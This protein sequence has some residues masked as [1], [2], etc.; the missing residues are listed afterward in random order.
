MKT[1]II[2]LFLLNA[3]SIYG[4]S[5]IYNFYKR[6]FFNKKYELS[7][8]SYITEKIKYEQILDDNSA[9]INGYYYDSDRIK[10]IDTFVNDELIKTEYFSKSGESIFVRNFKYDQEGR[11]EYIETIAKLKNEESNYTNK[12]FFNYLDNQINFNF[13]INYTLLQNNQL[14][15]FEEVGTG[16]LDKNY[17]PEKSQSQFLK[18]SDSENACYLKNEKWK[19]KINGYNYTCYVNKK[20]ICSYK[21]RI[22]KNCLVTEKRI[23][24]NINFLEK[25]ICDKSVCKR[26]TD[27]NGNKNYSEFECKNFF[28][29]YKEV[30]KDRQKQIFIHDEIIYL[31]NKDIVSDHLVLNLELFDF[32]YSDNKFTVY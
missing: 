18:N 15:S 2:L 8:N 30:I 27:L 1:K 10:F 26:K 24:G 7:C 4:Q 5:F 12:Y 3:M 17:K 29:D 16:F 25:E 9:Y 19:N 21:K 13:S 31:N 6:D 32:R 22:K 14:I 20:N 11:I 23:Y 28:D